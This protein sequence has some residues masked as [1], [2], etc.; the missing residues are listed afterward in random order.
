MKGLFIS[1]RGIAYP[2]DLEILSAAF[3]HF[4]QDHHIEPEGPEGTELA[5]TIMSLFEAG[6]CDEAA[7]RSVL[8][9]MKNG[10]LFRSSQSLAE[11]LTDLGN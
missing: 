2:E 3:D 9:S 11:H 1:S 10:T 8:D 4:C 5:R 7:I 6:L